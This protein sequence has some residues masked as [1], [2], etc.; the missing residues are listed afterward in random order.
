MHVVSTVSTDTCF[1][2]EEKDTT[3]V[4]QYVVSVVIN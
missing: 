3:A 2:L 1:P 4:M